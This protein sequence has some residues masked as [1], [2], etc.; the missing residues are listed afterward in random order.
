M[1][2][3]TLW[4]GDYHL[5]NWIFLFFLYSS[6]GWVWESI[7]MSIL[8]RKLLNR[9]F[10]N[11][12]CIPLYGFGATFVLATTMS[13]KEHW[14]AVFLIGMVSATILEEV[15]GRVMDALFDVQYWTY[16]GYP[17]NIDDIICIPATILWGFFSIF[18]MYVLNPPFEKMMLHMPMVWIY[19][20]VFVCGMVFMVDVTLSVK[21]AL[22]FK[23][24]MAKF[25]GGRDEL[26]RMKKRLDVM[27]AFYDEEHQYMARIKE[28]LGNRKDAITDSF[29][30][31]LESV[32]IRLEIMR[33]IRALRRKD[34]DEEDAMEV[35][36]LRE[37]NQK[38]VE[39]EAT[40]HIYGHRVRRYVKR[41]L[42]IN[43]RATFKR[44]G[45][46]LKDMVGTVKG[47][48]K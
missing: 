46:R 41:I 24:I 35:V 37:M 18:A 13:F 25:S 15:T 23:D 28:N 21:D 9:G 3:Q 7:Y 29:S 14:W 22:T 4:N 44:F 11:G 6:L 40:E 27:I 5:L 43:P 36:E 16:E 32:K 20:I 33:E 31:T 10:L 19:H 17:G 8:E 45:V 12:P 30:D 42:S 2:E 48:L 39:Q 38:Y 1:S 47:F 34:N 26:L